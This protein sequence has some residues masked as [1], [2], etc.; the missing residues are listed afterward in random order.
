MNETEG[1]RQFDGM[2]IV[3]ALLL[4]EHTTVL[5]DP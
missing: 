5:M 2:A 3:E 1:R 4:L